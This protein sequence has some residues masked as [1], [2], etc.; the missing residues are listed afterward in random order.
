M[1]RSNFYVFHF[2]H[3]QEAILSL[4]PKAD[5]GRI[6]VIIFIREYC[7]CFIYQQIM[8]K[9][10]YELYLPLSLQISETTSQETSEGDGLIGSCYA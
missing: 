10:V 7:K 2:L 4:P 5:S 6:V 3:V 8:A 1:N 9:D